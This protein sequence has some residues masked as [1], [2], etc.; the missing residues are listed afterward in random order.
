MDLVT[1]TLARVWPAG[2]MAIPPRL[3]VVIT[4]LALAV[5]AVPQVWHVC[6]IGVTLVHE[7]GHAVVGLAVGRR[8]TGFVVRGDT[9][10]A[11][12]TVGPD[13]GPGLVLTTWAGYP[14]PAVVGTGLIAAAA[15]GWAAPVLTGTLVVLGISVVRIRSLLTAAVLLG[16]LAAGIAL[17]WWRDDQVQTAVL[18]GVG[19]VLLLGAGRQCWTVSRSRSS[20]SDPAR[21]ATVTGIPRALW[22]ATFWA[23]LAAAVAGSVALLLEATA[24][25]P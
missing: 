7:L 6:R 23:V 3:V 22:L 19:V 12:V 15:H 5:T 8:F 9:S 11:T 16:T 4:L 21:L 10:G 13:R 2:E 25:L 17:W 14:A 20:G 24:L 18:L 1:Q